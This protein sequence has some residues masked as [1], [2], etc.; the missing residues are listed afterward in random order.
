[1]KQLSS[2]FLFIFLC[3]TCVYSQKNTDSLSVKERVDIHHSQLALPEAVAYGDLIQQEFLSKHLHVLA[4]DEFEGR[5]T[6]KEGQKKAAAYLADYFQSIGIA[7]LNGS[8]YQTFE[9]AEQIPGGTLSIHDKQFQFF[10]DFYYF[11]GFADTLIQTSE[12]LF[13]G[14]G[15]E[16]EKYSDYKEVDVKNKVILILSGEPL[17]KKGNSLLT[18]KSDR[19]AWST[20]T[21]KKTQLAYR[22]G[23]AAVLI[24]D[25]NYL[26]QREQLHHYIQKPTTRLVMDMKGE[27]EPQTPRRLPAFYISPQMGEMLLGKKGEAK[28]LAEK[29]S[30]TG[31]PLNRQLSVALEI[32]IRRET[33]KMTGEN[34]LAYIEGTDLKDE[35]IVITAHYDHLGKEG[36]LIYNGADDDGTGTVAL[37]NIAL[38]FRKAVEEG[39]GPRRSILIMPVS[40]EEKGLLGSYYY[41]ENPLFPLSQTITNLNI[42]MIGRNDKHYGSNNEYVY[43]IGSDKLSSDLHVISEQANALHTRLKLDYRYND[44]SDPNR[45][46]YRSDHYNFARK[47]I[48]VIFY[49]SGIH[50]DYHKPTDTVEKIDFPKVEKITRLIFFTAWDL[51]NREKR[52]ALDSK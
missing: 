35:L 52:P 29:I 13:L 27:K 1:M 40:G 12:V 10:E 3:I 26:K 22:K 50:E 16:E 14:Y 45:F 18:G 38:A 5:E 17:D 6:G 46:Y 51:A 37:M 15:I 11:Q 48:P 23:A 49:F 47:N 28:A 4:S 21:R 9:L 8:Y 39:K 36:D 30:K 20:D 19:S 43:I 42:D 32:N 33:H 34:V 2:A 25:Q 24:L 7:P 44:P 41:S 31:K